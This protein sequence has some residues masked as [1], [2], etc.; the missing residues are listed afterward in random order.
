MDKTK[1]ADIVLKLREIIPNPVCELNF[2][3]PFELLCAV[4][5]SAQ[6][7]DKRVNMVTGE[8]FEKYGAPSLLMNA[9]VFEVLRIISS[10][11][12]AKTKAMNL[13]HMAKILHEEYNDEVPQEF[14]RLVALPGVG[15]KTAS[16]VL[17]VGFRIP[18]MPV[19]T[20]LHRMA[21]RLGYIRPEDSVLK[22]EEAYKKYIPKEE[23]ID[24]HHL[25][26]LFGRYFC[27]ASAPNCTNCLLKNY[28]VYKETSKNNK[29]KK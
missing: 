14:D 28:C 4:M 23:W 1:S 10:V 22:A 5:L 24:A 20:H 26:L 16:V 7:T 6:T 21:I 17:A 2:T 11:G 13:V 25:F 12:L 3:T 9:D 15:R 29:D 18:A 19:D 27:K 8:L